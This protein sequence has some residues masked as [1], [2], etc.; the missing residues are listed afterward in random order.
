MKPK[1]G[2]F[3][4]SGCAGCMLSI[5]FL[6]DEILDIIGQVNLLSF[7]LIKGRNINDE[8]DLVFFEG[9]ICH[10]DDLEVLR[11][12][13]EKTKILVAFGSCA[14]T[15][16]IPAT[17]NFVDESKFNHLRHKKMDFIA[18]REPMPIDH[19]VDVEYHLPGCPPSQPEIVRFLKQVLLGKD[20]RPFDKPVCYEC[21]LNRNRCLLEDGKI[22]FGTL[23]QGGC[24]AICPNGGYECW[25]CRGPAQD[26]NIEEV[27]TLFKDKGIPEEQVRNRVTTFM[28]M[29]MKEHDKTLKLLRQDQTKK[30]ETKQE[31]K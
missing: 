7:S 23:T 2:V 16:G 4:A 9:V 20:F 6:E 17:R 3:G 5:P 1:V 26:V 22:C 19:Y 28:G 15:G 31:A 27:Y 12:V 14:C 21:K 8:F 25:G 13:R 18:D 10:N 30:Q 29:R 24:D 11:K